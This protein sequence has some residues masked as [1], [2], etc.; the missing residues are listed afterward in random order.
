MKK[1]RK[2]EIGLAG[3]V[4]L[5]VG[6]VFG[7]ALLVP[8]FSSQAIMTDKQVST[9]QSIDVTTAFINASAVNE[10]ITY[11]IYA[12]SDWKTTKCPLTSVAI[13]NGAGTALVSA[14]DYTLN[15]STGTYTLLSTAKTYPSATSNLTYVDSTFCADGYIPDSGGRSVTKL[16]GIFAVFTLLAFVIWKSDILNSFNF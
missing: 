1:N 6:I 8:I 5:F 9:N 10:S 3:L 12:Q 16:I 7:I 2:G 11:T 15:A 13:R 4:I 14:T